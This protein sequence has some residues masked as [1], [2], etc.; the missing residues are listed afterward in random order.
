MP[1]KQIGLYDTAFEKESCG[2]GFIAHIKGQASRKIISDAA[3][4]LE[5]MDHRGARGAE[6]NT[7]DGA[8]ILTGLP[9]AFLRRIAQKEFNQELP[10]SGKYAVGIV[11]LPVDNIA[12]RH[13]MNKVEQICNTEKQKIIGWRDL[14][15]QP[16]EANLGP[17][18]IESMPHMMQLFIAS[19]EDI[20]QE[21]FERRLYLIR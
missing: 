1:K 10:V 14:P 15:T 13:G 16:L 4:I 17:T 5:N 8:G 18:A 21:E 12:K 9:D 6:H 19:K 2:V 3:I 20:D 7:G 11:F